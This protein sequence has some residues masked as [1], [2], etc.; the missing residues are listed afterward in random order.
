MK[1]FDTLLPPKH[2]RVE[3]RRATGHD[4]SAAAALASRYLPG[5]LASLT[6]VRKAISRNPN[7]VMIFW[8]GGSVAGA[9]AMLML[10]SRGLEAL[11][12][13]G[14][15]FAEPASRE[16][17]AATDAPAAI[18]IWAVVAPGLASEGIAQ[19]SLFLRH[20]LYSAANLYTRPTTPGGRRIAE[21]LGFVPISGATA[22]LH[23]YLRLP[24]RE[25]VLQQAA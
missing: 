8:R 11:L 10:N 13:S 12:T 25:P 15:N 16:L 9:W 17:A 4:L 1:E 19:M 3:I 24:N 7:N 23:R 14:F 2:S 21:N 22:G 6:S 5:E 18:Y 20:P